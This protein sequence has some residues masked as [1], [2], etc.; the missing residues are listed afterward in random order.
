MHLTLAG[1]RILGLGDLG[2]N[3]LG[4]SFG[5][6]ALYCAAGGLLPS[7]VLP[8]V[9][10]VGCSNSALRSTPAY[11]GIPQ[12]RLR[13][14]EYEDL[15]AEFFAAAQVRSCLALGFNCCTHVPRCCGVD[16]LWPTTCALL[17]ICGV[18]KGVTMPLT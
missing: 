17:D 10:D 16:A 12:D 6:C 3:G 1:G 13:G 14:Q 15:V 18:C 7:Q 2:A 9:L 8:V 5:K 4:I 11:S